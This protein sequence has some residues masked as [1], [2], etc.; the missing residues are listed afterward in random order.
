MTP[1]QLYEWASDNIPTVVFNYCT[2]DDYKKAE[3]FL[4]CRFQQSR[5]IPGTQKLHCFI[6]F[7]IGRFYTKI[8]SNSSTRKEVKVTLSELDELPLEEIKGF[9]TAVHNSQ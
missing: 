6:P 4:E 1:R 5:T 7:K 9:V 3:T 2:T 8:F